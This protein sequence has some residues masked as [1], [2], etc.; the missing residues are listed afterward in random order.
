MS[1]SIDGGK[2]LGSGLGSFDVK[3]DKA[4][5]AGNQQKASDA[6]ASAKSTFGAE[7][8]VIDSQGNSQVHKMSIKE[9]VFTKPKATAAGLLAV[10]NL[11]SGANVDKTKPLAIDANI[12]AA[13]GGKVAIFSDEKDKTAVVG[14]DRQKV[15]ADY[16]TAPTDKKVNAAYVV[17]G[18]DNFVNKQMAKNVTSSLTAN[19]RNLGEAGTSINLLKDGQVKT[20]MNSLISELNT[21]SA[22]TSQLEGQLKDRTNKYN[23]DIAKPQDRL[24]NANSA[25]AKAN[26]NET[27]KVEQASEAVREAQY[28][29]VHDAENAL[30]NAKN[31]VTDGK[32]YLENAVQNVSKAQ[33]N[34]NRLENLK[35]NSENLRVENRDLERDNRQIEGNMV[36]YMYSRKEQL[37]SF[38]NT[39]N[40]KAQ[41]FDD[42]AAQE[43]RK[44]PAPAGAVT[45]DP[46]SNGGGNKPTTGGVN[47]DPF[48]NGGGKPTGNVNSDPFS[49][50][51]KPTGKPTGGVNADPFSNGGGKP[52]GNVN[53]DPFSN[54]GGNKP[55]GN[56]INSDPFNNGGGSQPAGNYRNDGLLQEYRRKAQEVKSDITTLD[57]RVKGLNQAIGYA[58]NYG[59]ESSAFR[60]AVSSLDAGKYNSYDY[61]FNGKDRDYFSDP[62]SDRAVIRNEFVVPYDQNKDRMARNN[63]AI[64]NNMNEY[65]NNIGNANKQ[66]QDATVAQSQASGNLAGAQS[67]VTQYTAELQRI[68]GRPA[69]PDSNPSV[70]TA[71]SDLDKTVKHK[72][73]T[74]G[75][76][77]PL[78]KEKTTA[79]GVVDQINKDYTTDKNSIN[80]KIADNANNAQQKINQTKKNIG[81]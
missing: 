9:G 35:E 36:T 1:G 6:M 77:A 70:K 26:D 37:S 64:R 2:Y 46:F 61:V 32:A 78:T 47:S 67:A 44:Q 24:N 55:T 12:A 38:M 41:Y 65:N 13:F 31:M 3:V 30:Q 22:S 51:S 66:L 60:N 59:M 39:L 34:V 5:V 14:Q 71:K 42:L 74:V 19:Y 10:D 8:V 16:L 57:M 75:E 21:L 63:N 29:G 27:A 73:A 28:P 4:A 50:G 25:W 17:A 58:K 15:A 54:G 53:S 45:N 81:I 62:S 11:A 69:Q 7:V 52:T 43:S 56:N 33:N 76:N 48:S 68:N 20:A 72:E 80:S 18:D 23:T 49:N 40:S 79:Q